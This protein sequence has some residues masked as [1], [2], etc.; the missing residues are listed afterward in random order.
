MVRLR[1]DLSI[2]IQQS[3]A[4]ELVKVLGNLKWE[5][6]FQTPLINFHDQLS[7]LKGTLIDPGSNDALAHSIICLTSTLKEWYQTQVG[8]ELPG[9][10][11]GLAFELLHS[12]SLV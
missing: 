3:N 6:F 10:W 1:E 11:S 8:W 7:S 12:W 2:H 4:S 5:R 9:Y